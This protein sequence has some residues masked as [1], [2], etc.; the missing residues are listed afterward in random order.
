MWKGSAYQL[1]PNSSL[2]GRLHSVM[3]WR[4]EGSNGRERCSSSRLGELPS[5]HMFEEK[6]LKESPTDW[7]A[8][9]FE[10]A[11]HRCNKSG[12][13]SIFP[14]VTVNCHVFGVCPSVVSIF[15]L[16]SVFW[17]WPK[18]AVHSPSP[19]P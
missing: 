13:F 3:A 19:I 18:N 5:T 9:Y 12:R 8:R 17:F 7:H 15:S 16:T 11:V 1:H 14:S 2:S 10:A 4:G 6:D